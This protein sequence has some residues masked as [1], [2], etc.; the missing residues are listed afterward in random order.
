MQLGWL[1]PTNQGVM[2]GDYISTSFLAGEQRVIGVFAAG[3]APGAD[4][5]LNQPML[6]AL[7]HTRSGTLKAEGSPSVSAGEANTVDTAF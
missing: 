4:G 1:A 6:A 7:E 2:V 5:A 3:S